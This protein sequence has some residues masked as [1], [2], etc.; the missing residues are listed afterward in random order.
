MW[1]PQADRQVLDNMNRT[2]PNGGYA[3]KVSSVVLYGPRLATDQ[4]WALVMIAVTPALRGSGRGAQAFRWVDDMFRALDQRLLVIE[5]SS[6]PRYDKPRTNPPDEH[7]SQ[8]R[9]NL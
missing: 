7:L 9:R 6:T 1:L 2:R 4:V 5:T 8:G 3:S